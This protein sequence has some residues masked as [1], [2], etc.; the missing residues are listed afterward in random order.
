MYSI[1]SRREF[2]S[3]YA[4]I[5]TAKTVSVPTVFWLLPW[6]NAKCLHLCAF[7]QTHRDRLVSRCTTGHLQ[8]FKCHHGDLDRELALGR[9]CG[10]DEG[11][12][13]E[14]DH[15]H[16]VCNGLGSLVGSPHGQWDPCSLKN[17]SPGGCGPGLSPSP[18][19]EGDPSVLDKRRGKC[20]GRWGRHPCSHALIFPTGKILCWG[21]CL[22]TKQGHFRGKMRLLL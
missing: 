21:V 1:P 7:S 9:G 15:K 3:L 12:R 8:R 11:P 14:Q 22:G 6:C 13:G 20:A 5:N 10:W 2:W 17:S 4:S 18:S 19:H 16:D